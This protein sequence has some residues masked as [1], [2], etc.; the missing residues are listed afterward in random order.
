MAMPSDTDVKFKAF[1]ETLFSKIG[2]QV[3][4]HY[5]DTNLPPSCFKKKQRACVYNLCWKCGYEPESHIV[6]SGEDIES[7]SLL[8]KHQPGIYNIC[9]E[10]INTLVNPTE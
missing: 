3:I 9:F 10:T 2:Y 6:Y 8:F 5:Q 1:V 7:W 4:I